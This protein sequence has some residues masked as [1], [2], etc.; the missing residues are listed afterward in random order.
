MYNKILGID[1]ST[2]GSGG[3][4]R[5][6]IEILR[7]FKPA[8]HNFSKI[9]VWGSEAL[10]SKIPNNNYVIKITHPLLNK[11]ILHRFLWQ[12][13]FR[14]NSFRE[15]N[16]S[17]LFNPFGTYIG[18]FRPY[19]TMSQNMLVF[20][21]NEQRYFGIS[22]L[23]AKFLLLFFIQKKS[24][25]NSQGIIFISNY[26]K[27]YIKKHVNYST[28]KTITIYNGISDD[29]KK[30]PSIQYPINHYN[31]NKPFKIL[32]VSP[33][34]KYKHHLEVIE[35]FLKLKSKGYPIILQLVG[36]IGQKNYATQLKL[37]IDT[38]NQ[39]NKY[40][41]WETDID[42]KGVVDFY[43]NCE[44]FIFASSCENMPNILIEALASSLPIVCSSSNPMPEFLGS[45]GYYFNPESIVDIELKIENMLND[46]TFRSE[47]ALNAQNIAKQYKWE[48]CSDETFDFL[49]SFININ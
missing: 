9:V 44:A 49:Y 47:L 13:K 4:Q 33:I 32:Y 45:N 46:T 29:F 37:K 30:E 48:T 6:L 40:I 24:F 27:Q 31:L 25:N 15:E 22:L 39:E 18:K 5:H 2:N 36:G 43:H 11:T 26:A 35:A 3:V 14:F 17:I 1:A 42:L 7:N 21:K 10:L 34:F 23:R 28:L 12:F 20:D 41:F 19:V 38:L 8:K 16:I